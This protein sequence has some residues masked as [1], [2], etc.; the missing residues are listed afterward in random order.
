[1]RKFAVMVAVVAWASGCARESPQRAQEEFEGAVTMRM[2]MADRLKVDV[3]TLSKASKVRQEMT[4][5]GQP[6]ISIIDAEA[7]TGLMLMP[8]QKAYMRIDFKAMARR[9][10]EMP[11]PTI[12][13]VGTKET[14]AGHR[15]ENYDVVVPSG[16]TQM[17]VAKDLGFYMAGLQQSFQTNGIGS[18]S[19]MPEYVEVFRNTFRDGFFPLKMTVTNQG[20]TMTLTVTKIEPRSLSDEQFELDA[21]AGYTE[22]RPPS[23]GPR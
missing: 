2:N 16:T 6:V 20:A 23:G 13:P 5:M 3:V 11:V 12:T 17:C 19:N 10:G 18:Q 7:G 14:I 15:C 22:L 1:M 21:P 9:V 8:Q 4:M